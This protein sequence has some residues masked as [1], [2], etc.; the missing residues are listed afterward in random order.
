[1]VDDEKRNSMLETIAMK[2]QTEG[3]LISQFKELV[4]REH[5][6]ARKKG[7]AYASGPNGTPLLRTTAGGK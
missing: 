4:S 3:E 1:M 6:G 5:V 7:A 2:E